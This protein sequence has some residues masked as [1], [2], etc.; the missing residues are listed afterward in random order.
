[1]SNNPVPLPDLYFDSFSYSVGSIVFGNMAMASSIGFLANPRS[2][3]ERHRLAPSAELSLYCVLLFWLSPDV[4][5]T[6]KHYSN[7]PMKKVTRA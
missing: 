2:C 6:G 5:L 3:L 1:M 7:H 4:S